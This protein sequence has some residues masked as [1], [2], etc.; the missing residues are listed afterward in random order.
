MHGQGL[1]DASC[2]QHLMRFF[3]IIAYVLIVPVALIIWIFGL[4]EDDKNP[5]C[6]FYLWLLDGSRSKE[7]DA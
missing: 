2:G 6:R 7:N 1:I 3:K 4:W 5:L